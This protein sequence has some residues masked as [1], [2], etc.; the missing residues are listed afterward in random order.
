MVVVKAKTRST[1]EST[2]GGHETMPYN[3]TKSTSWRETYGDA[4]RRVKQGFNEGDI[5]V[6]RWFRSVEERGEGRK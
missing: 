3:L 5:A 4:G 1:N 6:G 2:D